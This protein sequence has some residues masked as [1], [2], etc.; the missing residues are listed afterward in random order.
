MDMADYIDKNILCEAYA[1]VELPKNITKAELE[2]IKAHLTDF[3]TSRA[4]FFVYPDV[5]VEVDFREGS[6]KTYITIAGSIYAAIIGYGE[7]RHGVDYLYTDVKRLADTMVAESLFMTKARH[8]D[9]KRTEARTGVVGSLKVL[10]DDM[11]TLESSI[12][13]VSLDEVTRRIKGI[14]NDAEVLLTNVRAEKDV[15]NIEDE[16]DRFADNLPDRAP[17]PQEKRPEDSAIIAYY[18][19]LSEF[20]KK[21]GKKKIKK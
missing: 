5:A 14:Q 8:A 4:K 21:F 19:V 13:Q 2:K 6:L 11:N 20:R 15:Q 16:L 17:H 9:I 12:G 10:V 1:H 7:F 3:A 18:D